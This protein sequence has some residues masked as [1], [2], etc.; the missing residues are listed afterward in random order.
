MIQCTSN[1][2]FFC[3]QRD[4]IPSLFVDRHLGNMSPMPADEWW[5]PLASVL[6]ILLV[7]N[8]HPVCKM[9]H[10]RNWCQNIESTAG[11][12]TKV[13]S[14]PLSPHYQVLHY[15]ILL[16]VRWASQGLMFRVTEHH[17][18]VSSWERKH[19][20][21]CILGATSDAQRSITNGSKV[22][23]TGTTSLVGMHTETLKK[24]ARNRP[25]AF[26]DAR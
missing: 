15:L 16:N 25:L 14:S 18:I 5:L 22:P 8:A 3:T 13:S 11:F 2:Q 9:S 10:V 21:R 6:C 24:T 4:S 1:L 7:T 12:T 17:W 19:D 26:T 20:S 23:S